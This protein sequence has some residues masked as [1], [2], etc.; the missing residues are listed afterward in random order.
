MDYWA[1]EDRGGAKIAHSLV[2]D[3]YS[4]Q[5]SSDSAQSRS[6]M[7]QTAGVLEGN[8]LS[9]FKKGSPGLNT[10]IQDDNKNQQMLIPRLNEKEIV[11]TFNSIDINKDGYITADEIACFFEVLEENATDA[12]IDEMIRMLDYE[13]SG[14]VCIEE[15]YKLATGKD[16]SSNRRVSVS[17]PTKNAD[18]SK[19]D[20]IH[21]NTASYFFNKDSF[22]GIMKKDSMSISDSTT[23]L[24]D[25]DRKVS[26]TGFQRKESQS[27]ESEKRERAMLVKEF[28]RQTGLDENTFLEK[29]PKSIHS[30]SALIINYKD[31][32]TYFGLKD[33]ELS[34]YV[35]LLF[36]TEKAFIDLR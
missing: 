23:F 14:R 36:S 19:L 15:F 17:D 4:K 7:K 18:I 8:K 9:R 13:G 3:S 21:D 30:Q 6:G 12:E 25:Y 24:K 28:M 2:I 22:V 5:L 27:V 34:Q 33:G 11:D 1:R 35:F 16:L 31:F 10:A 32:L 20:R 26:N 29:Y